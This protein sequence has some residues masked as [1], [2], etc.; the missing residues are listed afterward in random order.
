[1]RPWAR[2]IAI[3]VVAFAALV[4]GARPAEAQNYRRWYL[5]EGAANT[6]FNETILIGN[7]NATVANVTIRLLP[8]GQP[9]FTPQQIVVPA[10]SRYTFNV[11][12]V[13]GLPQGAVAA[14]VESDVDIVVERSMTW[15]GASQ[16]G[17]HNSG[18]VLAP[19][20]EWFLAEGVTGFFETFVLIT[21][22]STAT[23]TVDVTFLRET[24]GPLVR[25]YTIA[26]SGRKT[27][28]VNGEVRDDAGRPIAEPFS[29]VVRQQG[30][31]ADLVVERAMYWN[32]FE[33]GHGAAA[34]TAPATTWLFAEGVCGGDP[35]SP[36]RPTCCW[37]T[38][39]RA[40]PPR[41]SRSSAIRAGR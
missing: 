14:I 8:E 13:T 20:G 12:G 11:N 16:R 19:A 33:G 39:A 32:S 4:A 37:P 6:F 1:M 18:G 23:Q 17:G 24:S 30:G 5:A 35:A 29:T 3:V 31:G 34:V 41:R 10:T 2:I 28:Y 40:T 21:N 36:S 22:T 25:T 26:P 15:P 27:V 7:P 9:P 38:R